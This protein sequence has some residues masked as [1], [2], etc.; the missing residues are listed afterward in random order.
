MSAWTSP[1]IIASCPSN[2]SIRHFNQSD[3]QVVFA[4]PTISDGP[5][6]QSTT[7]TALKKVDAGTNAYGEGRGQTRC[8]GAKFHARIGSDHF[9][10]NS[11]HVVAWR[12]ARDGKSIREAEEDT[13]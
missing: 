8:E 7:A 10:W 1:K 4:P 11:H 3:C 2:L 6:P 13:H 9:C 5:S 12:M